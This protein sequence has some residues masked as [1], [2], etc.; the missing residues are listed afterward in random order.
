VA[1]NGNHQA[2]DFNG[3]TAENEAGTRSGSREKHE[4]GDGE[5]EPGWH[6]E[7]SGV[8]HLLFLSRFTFDVGPRTG[9]EL[10]SRVRHARSLL[11]RIAE[12]KVFMDSNASGCAGRACRRENAEAFT[13]SFR[14]AID[15]EVCASGSTANTERLPSFSA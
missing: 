9:P 2:E 10:P 5:K 4:R 6:H 7:Q 3:D 11:L 8:F 15:N 12:R 14:A 1:A 13:V